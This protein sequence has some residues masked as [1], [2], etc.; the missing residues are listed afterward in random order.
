MSISSKHL[1]CTCVKRLLLGR[2]SFYAPVKA[3]IDGDL[4]EQ[5]NLLPMDK[6]RAIAQELD[7]MPVEIQKKIEDMRVL[8][9]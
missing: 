4:C 1:K 5:Y 6:K 3:V 8:A 7:R 9:A 2:Q